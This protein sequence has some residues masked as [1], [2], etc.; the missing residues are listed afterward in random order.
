M[1]PNFSG[2]V[3]D[4]AKCSELSL[5][6][7]RGLVHELSCW[8][9]N[10]PEILQ[11]FSRRELIQLICAEL[12]K[13]RKYTGVTK[14]KMIA[15]LLRL[16]SEKKNGKKVEVGIKKKRKK[17]ISL[18]FTDHTAQVHSQISK[19][20]EIKTLVCQN[21]A[22]RATLNQCDKYCKRCSC[23]ICY[24]FDDNKDPSLWLVCSSDAPYCGESCGMSCHLKCA[25]KS[26]KAGI[27]RHGHYTKLDGSFYCVCCGKVNWLIGSWR[28]QLQ[29]AKEARRVDILCD[30]LSLSQKIL[31]GTEQYKELHNIVNEAVKKL[32]KELG[33]L[34]KVSLVMARG[35]VNRLACGAEVQKLCALAVDAL[36]AMLSGTF[37]GLVDT[38]HPK[39][40]GPQSF[41]IH[42]EDISPTSLVVSLQFKDESFE[43]TIIGCTLWHQSSNSSDYPQD[44]TF[45]IQRP[46][47]KCKISGLTPS[48][49]Y[50][51]KASPFSST[52]ELGKWEA[53]CSTLKSPKKDQEIQSDSQKGSTN[54][55]DNNQA[56]NLKNVVTPLVDTPSNAN[57]EKVDERQYE[58][59]VKV[60]RWLECEGYMEKEFRVKFLT[61]FSL[62]AT[63]RE[64]RVVSAFIDVLIDEP[65]SLVAQLADAFMD[66]ICTRE[67]VAR[68][69]LCTRL[70]S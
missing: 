49:E 43:E 57:K 5:E 12:G 4:P 34:D 50:L 9:D 70:F 64:R 45:I 7:K 38:G 44:P 69:G 23:C 13:E 30:R 60:V 39:I 62:K 25:L 53:R 37:Q 59:C 55:S 61:W 67:E 10:A 54:T 19:S 14:P 46:E 51:F 66:G 6:E 24:Q 16:V 58:Y 26:E 3:I 20:E 18:Q 41:Q 63:A 31:K 28:K 11:S 22:C 68:K 21:L 32:K 40:L 1:E 36:D 15:H 47:T 42:F 17:E 56:P 8:A 33:P 65:E 48:T 2:F 35:I 27:S 29:V 52:K